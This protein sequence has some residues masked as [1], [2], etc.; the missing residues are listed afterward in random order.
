MIDL[1]RLAAD[2]AALHAKAAAAGVI[3]D[4]EMTL[5]AQRQSDGMPL[6]TV[7]TKITPDG[8]PRT[9]ARCT[10][11]RPIWSGLAQAATVNFERPREHPSATAGMEMILQH[12]HPLALN[13]RPDLVFLDHSPLHHR[14]TFVHGVMIVSPPGSTNLLFID[15]GREYIRL[16]DAWPTARQWWPSQDSFKKILK[17][18]K[19]AETASLAV[20]RYWLIENGVHLTSH[21]RLAFEAALE[22]L[23]A[24][25]LAPVIPLDPE[26]V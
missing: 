17:G 22:R 9:T 20:A 6:G 15:H 8:W 3:Y 14:Y 12:E 24:D 5:T 4:I 16:L 1:D 26:P 18:C 7:R 2:L 21:E 19:T 13:N 10:T 25:G 23:A 11:G